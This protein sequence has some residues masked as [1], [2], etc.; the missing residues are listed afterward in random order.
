M[1][2]ALNA[3]VDVL[4]H[5]SNL[6]LWKKRKDP[7]CPLC[8]S[9]QSLL[10]VLNN[11]S[12]ARDARRYNT[13]HDAVLSVIAAVVKPN[14]PQ[15]STLTVDIGDS[16]SFPL[17]IVDTDLRPDLVW[18]D[19]R[20]RYLHMV[21][22]TVCFESNFVEAAERK[23]A[24]YMDLVE[25]SHTK[26]YETSLLTLQVGSRG[27]PDLPGFAKILNLSSR[28]LSVLLTAMSRQALVGSFSI[29]CSRNRLC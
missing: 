27:V 14:I 7:S 6:H 21:E 25:Q 5:N 29:W 18:W 4:P 9:N 8:G 23:S 13:R 12:V 1:K 11:C 2:F 22:L 26:G 16:Y 20:H 19:E 24:K 15:T 10:H 28:E 17:H 3:A